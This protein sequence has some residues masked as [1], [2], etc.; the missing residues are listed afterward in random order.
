MNGGG[1]EAQPVLLQVAQVGEGDHGGGDGGPYIAPLP[2]LI[3]LKTYFI[4]LNQPYHD[5]GDSFSQRDG[6]AR[7]HGYNH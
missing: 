5:H 7:Y 3:L 6:V 1:R 2:G 4:R